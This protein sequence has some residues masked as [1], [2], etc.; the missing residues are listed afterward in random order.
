M[1][2]CITLLRQVQPYLSPS[3]EKVAVYLLANPEKAVHQSI[4]NLAKESGASTAAVVRLCKRVNFEGYSD[5]KLALAKEVYGNKNQSEGPYIFDLSKTDGVGSIASMMINTICES[6]T[7]LKSVLSTKQLEL[8]V[9][10]IDSADKILLAGIGASAL[11]ALDLYQK[12]GRLG[13]YSN[14]P[15]EPDLQI[16]NACALGKN[17]VCVVFSYSGENASMRQVAR[18]AREVAAKVIAI[19]RIGGNSL[20]RIADIVLTVPDSEALYRQGATLS[21]LNQLVV[22]DIL[23]SSLIARRNDADRYIVKTWQS[24]SHADNPAKQSKGK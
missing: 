4:T 13:I 8:A 14:F 16:V 10:A 11:G 24:V 21:R 5:L 17:S 6:I 23:Y 22:V 20:S 2:G 1:D 15:N 9:E 19:T 12:L 3:E 18:K 7:S